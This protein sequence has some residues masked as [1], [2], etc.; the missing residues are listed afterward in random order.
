MDNSD[1]EKLRELMHQMTDV[2]FSDDLMQRILTKSKSQEPKRRKRLWF[3]TSRFGIAAAGLVAASTLVVVAL[4][5]PGTTKPRLYSSSTATNQQNQPIEAYGMMNAPIQIQDLHIGQEPGYPGKSEVI[6][7]LTNETSDTI[8]TTDVFGILAFSRTPSLQ[9]LADA[10]WISF[11]N[12]PLPDEPIPP[13]KSVTW[14]FHPVGA[15]HDVKFALT[16]TPHLLFYS[17]KLVNPEK[18]DSTWRFSPLKITDTSVVL[19]TRIHSQTTN[20]Q[21]IIVQ[22]DFTNPL[23]QSVD[24]SHLL[25]F[26]WFDPTESE[27][28]TNYKTM[29]FITHV[30]AGTGNKNMLQPG[31]TVHASFHVI[32]SAKDQYFTN[33]AH[34]VVLYAPQ[35]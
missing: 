30:S 1:D 16:E 25:C 4:N 11:V 7:T 15:P 20:G 31:E 24:L 34:V 22:A 12:G 9:N 32:G 6:A 3:R 29:R 27:Q 5:H 14:T 35:Q 10:D 21:S 2:P 19:N 33:A 28:F 13:H 18:A 26:I 23:S 17:S 8:A